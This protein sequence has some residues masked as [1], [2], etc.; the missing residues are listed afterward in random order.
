ME[1][2]I[3]PTQI[4]AIVGGHASAAGSSKTK[5]DATT[6]LKIG[7]HSARAQSTPPPPANPSSRARNVFGGDKCVA[8][9]L[10]R[11]DCA[12]PKAVKYKG[13]EGAA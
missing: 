2:K 10:Y 1:K 9:V 13:A 7:A 12:P 4:E 11:S 3:P 6:R 5:P 8:H